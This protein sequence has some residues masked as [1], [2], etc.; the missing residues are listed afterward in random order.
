M[1]LTIE[2]NTEEIKN[3]L[4]AIGGS[5]EHEENY[6]ANG[7]GAWT[8]AFASIS[9]AKETAD[10]ALTKANEALASTKS[11]KSNSYFSSDKGTFVSA[12]ANEKTL[13]VVINTA[14]G[15][16]TYKLIRN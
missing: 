5:K 11:E 13:T 2:G 8:S 10:E 14:T 1:K 7:N 16:K 9:D 15:I 4:Q 12:V 6:V 3:V